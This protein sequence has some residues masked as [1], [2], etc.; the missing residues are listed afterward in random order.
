LTTIRT[1][2]R[3]ER[4]RAIDV[5][6]LAFAADPVIRWLWPEPHQYLI[7]FPTLLEGFGGRAFD[8][9]A[10]LATEGF[11]GCAMWLPPGIG[12]DEEVLDAAVRASV[13]P[14][15]A[16]ELG[17]IFEEM[18]ASVPAAPHWHLAFIGV[19]PLAHG[20]GIGGALLDHA[21]ERVDADGAQAYLESTN[22]RNITLYQRFGFEVTREIRVGSAPPL[23]PMVRASH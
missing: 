5:Q 3:S 16:S 7:N 6:L 12:P 17:E 14:S 23:F 22:P 10:A 2:R 9:G 15:I 21:L 19:D 1:V 8:E 11:E 18:A 13:R 4:L 20:R